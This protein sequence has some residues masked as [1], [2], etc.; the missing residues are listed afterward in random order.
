V[1]SV[2]GIDLHGTLGCREGKG[3]R[4]SN[5]FPLLS[6][7]MRF[8]VSTGETVYIVSGPPRDEV[9]EEMKDLGMEQGV[10]FTEILSL[11]DFLREMGAD[12]WQD[13]RGRW[14]CEHDLWNTLK[15]KLAAKYKIDV[16]VDNQEEYQDAMPSTTQFI[17][18]DGF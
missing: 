1:A 18:V 7:L 9:A 15:G 17:L 16:V 11:V 8:W 13:E 3:L 6:G 2:Y 5:L 4:P 10:H 14:W 12:L